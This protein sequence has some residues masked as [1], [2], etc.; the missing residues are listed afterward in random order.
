MPKILTVSVAAYNVQQYLEEAL[1]PFADEKWN[2]DIEVFV[3]DDGGNDASLDIAKSYAEKYPAI[4][5]PIHK[6]NGGW[7]STVNYGIE[8]ANGTYFKQLDGDD[9]FDKEALETFIQCL[10]T[11]TED[12][13]ITPFTSFEDGTGNVIEKVMFPEKYSFGKTIRINE[14]DVDFPFQMHSIAFKT[15]LLKENKIKI[16]EHCFYT[17]VEYLLKGLSTV[18]TVLFCS[19]DLY[20]YRLA[21]AGQSVSVAG[22]I[23]HYRE[24]LTVLN[25]LLSDLCRAEEK[26]VKDAVINAQ[27][28][29][30]IESQYRI[31][32]LLP[33]N[34]ENKRE[35]IGFDNELR[36][37]APLLYGRVASYI[38]LMRATGFSPFAFWTF[39]RQAVHKMKRNGKGA[40]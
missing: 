29:K 7:G 11:A 10:K 32:L 36:K 30:M 8:H 37:N 21:R 15:A 4:F 27:I 40:G 23:K 14:F 13:I 16:T 33:S 34:K 12:A 22:Y 5:I 19:A 9:Y 17:D 20:R 6:E 18:E 24:H 28:L 35:L 25:T 3:I 38:K 26:T 2:E 31:F 1:T 39:A